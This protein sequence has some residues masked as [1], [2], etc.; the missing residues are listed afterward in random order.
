MVATDGAEWSLVDSNELSLGSG[1][2]RGKTYLMIFYLGHG[3]L[4]CAEQ[5][6]KFVPRVDEFDDAGIEIIAISS[7]ELEG[8][9]KSID[10]IWRA[11][12]RFDWRRTLRWKFSKSSAPTM[13]LKTSPYTG[14]F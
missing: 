12:C 5:L 10:G 13:I 8:L 3:C 7:D 14:L 9:Q 11:R 4:H 6:Q 2:F 1:D